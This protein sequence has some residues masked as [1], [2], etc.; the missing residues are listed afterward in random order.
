MVYSNAMKHILL[1]LTILL[2]LTACSRPWNTAHTALEMVAEATNSVDRVARSQM[3]ASYDEMEAAIL[4]QARTDD[5]PHERQYYLDLAEARVHGWINLFMAIESM[6]TALPG[7][8]DVL[9][10]WRRTGDEQA[11]REWNAICLG[12]DSI[13]NRITEAMVAAAID[14]PELWEMVRPALRPVCT[15]VVDITAH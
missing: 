4:E 9:T 10:I 7:A 6:R 3:P 11:P 13:Q 14:I 8:E 2:S 15:F 1:I 5:P 12:L